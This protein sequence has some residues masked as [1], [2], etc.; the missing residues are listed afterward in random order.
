MTEPLVRAKKV[1][2]NCSYYDGGKK[3]VAAIDFGTTCCTVEYKTS[4]SKDI[5][6][7]RFERI[8]TR[9]PNAVMIG[10]QNDGKIT[11]ESYGLAAQREYNHRGTGTHP[12]GDM[13]Y[14]ERIKMMLERDQVCTM[15]M[16]A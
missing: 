2:A 3:C 12:A 8:Y 4:W 11:V 1:L 6:C 10:I 13:I 15:Q 16:L 9:V 7:Y 14:F 5:Q